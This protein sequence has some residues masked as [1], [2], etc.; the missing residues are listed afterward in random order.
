MKERISPIVKAAQTPDGVLEFMLHYE[1]VM[2]T[3]ASSLT[4]EKNKNDSDHK[5]WVETCELICES[6][7]DEC[8]KNIHLI[9]NMTPYTLEKIK[10]IYKETHSQ[11]IKS[12]ELLNEKEDKYVL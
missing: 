3:M 2:G 5:K 10:K 7:Y 8:K 6:L 4:S 1:V 12:K 11:I 9:K